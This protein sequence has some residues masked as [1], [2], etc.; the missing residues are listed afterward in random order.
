MVDLE[1][2]AVAE[3]AHVAAEAHREVVAEVSSFLLLANDGGASICC[4]W[5]L[6]MDNYLPSHQMSSKTRP[7]PANTAQ[8]SH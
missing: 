3:A 5:G 1:V 6:C 8:N 7:R 4:I 2:I